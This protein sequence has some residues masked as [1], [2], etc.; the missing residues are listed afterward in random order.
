MQHHLELGYLGVDVDDPATFDSFLADVVG[1]EPGAPTSDGRSTWRDDDR[2]QR[3]LVGEGEAND[4]AFVGFEATDA[5]AFATTRARLETAGYTLTEGSVAEC[6]ARRV[7]GLVHT[8]SPFGVRIELAHGLAH[9]TAPFQSPLVPGGFLT[10]GVGFGHV[11]FATTLF[12]ESHRFLTEG[13]GLVQS[14][15]VE[16]ELAPGIDLEVRFYHCN[17]RHHTLAVAH[18]PFEL[19]QHLHHV[20]VEANT[21]DDVGR[22]FDRAW[23]SGLGIANGLGRH[24]NDQMF[25]FYVVTPAGF[26]L[27]FG[28]GARTIGDDWNENRKYDR[29]SVWGHQPL[30]HG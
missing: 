27:E 10:D 9:A 6:E 29:I 13:L 26:Q 3:L 8:L 5:A 1:L 23:A 22:A 21:Q 15:W 18:T 20:M 30:S 7:A 12:E 24:D 16:T 19:P 11:V 4:V 28:H 14:D 17:A 25:S 2:A